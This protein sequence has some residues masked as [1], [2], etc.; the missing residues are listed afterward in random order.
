MVVKGKIENVIYRNN[1]NGYTVVEIKTKQDIFTA[2]G[3]FPIV[4]IGEVL[5][6]EG[7]FKVNK[8]YGEQFVAESVK[9]QKP[10]D[11][12]SIVKYLSCGLI[13]GVGEVTARNIVRTFGESTLEVIDTDPK[14]LAQVRG[15]SLKKANDIH[16]TYQDIKKMQ[17][18]VMF[19]Q[20]YDISISMAVKIFDKYK[21]KTEEVLM[22]NPYILIDDIEGI[23]FKTADKIAMKLGIEFDS[24]VRIKAGIVFALSE[25]AEKQGSTIAYIDE[26][27]E[28][29]K[30]VLEI[31]DEF[32]ENIENAL[33]ELEITGLIKKVIHNEKEALAISKYYNMEKFISRKLINLC[34]NSG[35]SQLGN[36]KEVEQ[37]E[38]LNKIK[39]H[40]KQK[41]A[42]LAG[43]SEG[44]VV[45]TGGPGTG[46]TT[47][48]KGILKIF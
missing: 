9:I 22:S 33:V 1:E 44:V 2:T 8:M 39:L 41:E 21:Y 5:E 24:Q 47:I 25:I 48:I 46:K 26:L 17:E 45:I 19:L 23:G 34:E 27:F 42:V 32:A 15:I 14:M 40:E 30:L 29:T 6:L 10:T 7:E 18:A 37:Y 36:E 38:I 13:S 35:I 43:T 31:D 12:E 16:N 4:G 28:E 3:K 11:L 20:K